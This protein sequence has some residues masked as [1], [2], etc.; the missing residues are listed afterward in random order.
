[1]ELALLVAKEA[2]PATR[3]RVAAVAVAVAALLVLLGL[4][5]QLA[6]RAVITHLEPAAV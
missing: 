3:T 2:R 1:M 5:T 6:A 4:A